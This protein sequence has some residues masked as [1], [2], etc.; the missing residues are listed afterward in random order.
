MG[1]QSKILN[2]QDIGLI[3]DNE[4]PDDNQ[5]EESKVEA[6]FS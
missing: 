1:N 5:L 6:S 3:F 4:F 2:P